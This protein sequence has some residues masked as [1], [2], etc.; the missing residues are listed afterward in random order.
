VRILL[1]RKHPGR[2]L[3]E[4]HDR[5]RWAPGPNATVREAPPPDPSTAGEFAPD[6]TLTGLIIR[7]VADEV[8][9]LPQLARRANVDPSA[10]HQWRTRHRGS[11]PE[12]IAGDPLRWYWPTVAAG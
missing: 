2:W 6:E 11:F 10:V 4:A 7:L 3:V 8:V 5:R 9:S 1:S 12:P